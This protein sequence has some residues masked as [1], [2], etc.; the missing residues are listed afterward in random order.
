M[1]HESKQISLRSRFF[2]LALI[3]CALSAC[4]KKGPLYLPPGMIPVI[5]PV[6]ESTIE[7]TLEPAIT[8]AVDA[9]KKKA[10]PVTTPVDKAQP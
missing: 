6:P 1:G 3:L 5:K 10:S 2:C 7:S 4:G 8:P 9:S